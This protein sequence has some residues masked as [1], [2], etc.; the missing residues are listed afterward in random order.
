[1]LQTPSPILNPSITDASSSAFLLQVEGLSVWL[2]TA[3]GPLHAVRDVSFTLQGGKVLCLV[4]ESGCGKS[5][6]A[7]ALLQLL[8]D[9]ACKTK[10]SVYLQEQDLTRC[11]EKDLCHIRG[12]D[13]A[14]IFQEPMTSLN[15]VMSVG[16]Q[17]IEPLVRHLKYS[18]KA[19]REKIIE[20]F[21]QVGIPAAHKRFDEY[22][23][24]LSGGMRQRVM[25]ATALACNPSLLVADEPTT[26]LDVT[27]Q[28]QI[29]Q[30]L[31]QQMQERNMGLVLITHDLGVVAEMADEV[32]VMYAGHMVE[33]APVHRLFDK[34]LHPYTQGL[35]GA[36]P[37]FETRDLGPLQVVPGT[38]P[39][40][41]ELCHELAQGCPFRPRCSHAMPVCQTM[42]KPVCFDEG[43][44]VACWLY[45]ATQTA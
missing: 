16:M 20:L 3:Y 30:L 7:L 42:P 27:I 24:Q 5:M 39:T 23:H 14:M 41:S 36:S 15:P 12:K 29:L 28:R 10:G 4:G 2:D 38:V 35:M 21:H 22:P 6:T 17:S 37:S 1:M 44:D 25:I 26:A 45:A 40:A 8:P 34:P 9:A 19:A 32:G 31:R 13:V 33:K 43:Q 11:S 18:K